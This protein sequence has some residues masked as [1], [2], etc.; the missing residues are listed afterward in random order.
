LYCSWQDF[1]TADEAAN[2]AAGIQYWKTGDYR[3]YSVNPP[4]SKLIASFPVLFINPDTS[5]LV[6][7]T[8]VD[9]RIEWDVGDRFAQSNAP[10]YRQIVFL[11]RLAGIA[12]S[13][14]G[15][16]I[17]YRWA[18][19]LFGYPGGLFALM[20]WCFEP[21][22]LAHAHFATADLPAAVMA[23]AAMSSFWRFNRSPSWRLAV[24]AGVILGLA[25]LVKFT[26]VVL[27]PC[28]LIIWL[29]ANTSSSFAD[30]RQPLWARC[31]QFC[32]IILL[33][34]ATINVGYECNGTG[35]RLDEFEF[36]SRSL[37]DSRMER[38]AGANAGY[39]NRFRGRLV[40]KTVIPLPSEYVMGIDIQRHGIESYESKHSYL[41]GEWRVGGWWY[42][43]IYACAV[44]IPLG[45]WCLLLVGAGVICARVRRGLS[46]VNVAFVLL[47][48]LMVVVLV[49]FHQD[50][51][52]H[53]R[54]VLPVFPFWMIGIGAAGSAV[55]GR[56]VGPKILVIV[57]L[58]WALWSSACVYPYCVSYFNEAAG[59][60]E[61]GYS[62]LSGTNVD[63]GQ[64]LW[65]L[66]EWVDA[67]PDAG[68]LRLAY[69]NHVDPRITGL[70]F[71]LP[72][73]GIG[74][75][76]L[77]SDIAEQSRLGPQPGRFAVSIR[78]VQG[79]TGSLPDG[80][81]GYIPLIP[82]NAY[83]YFQS[84]TPSA[85][86]GYSILIYDISVDEADSVRRKMALC[87]LSCQP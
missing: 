44:K 23:L 58:G 77:P 68:P 46:W 75:G 66:K 63:M 21:N 1:V 37:G 5:A 12:W 34:V 13:V 69:F 33:S 41:G 25:E 54:Y 38:A 42:Y 59:G 19:S 31:L 78:F 71:E 80:Q 45:D 11:A 74:A 43:Y 50:M 36:V 82:L 28:F 83:S 24:F 53:L 60:P 81:G 62:R 8:R 87:P 72:P 32:T 22:I 56:L 73:F 14:L 39:G 76:P 64:D 17:I 55:R 29:C 27:Y 47:L 30:I 85:R 40:G 4:L 65:R 2:I 6:V 35:K 9:N 16:M 86:A 51:N 52:K 18:N 49:S 79:S 26:L 15:A 10:R 67:N 20:A 7:D 3:L 57:S 48:P 70:A 84:F 61:G